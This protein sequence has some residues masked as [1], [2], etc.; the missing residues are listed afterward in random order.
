MQTVEIG[1][2]TNA[3]GRQDSMALKVLNIDVRLW[4]QV[5][6]IKIKKLRSMVHTMVENRAE[7]VGI[8]AGLK[9]VSEFIVCCNVNFHLSKK[10]WKNIENIENC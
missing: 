3:H 6:Q 7:V 8:T 10:I 4:V 1:L 2:A 5:N 9:T